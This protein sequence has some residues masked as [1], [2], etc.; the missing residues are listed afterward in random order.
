[1]G[2]VPGNRFMARLRKAGCQSGFWLSSA[3][4][5]VAEVAGGAGFDFAVIDAEHSPNTITTILDQ[6]RVLEAA[7][8]DPIVRP[9]AN[10]AIR[11]R[12]CLDIG[13]RTILVPMVNTAREAEEAVRATRYPPAGI[14]GVSMGH[15]AF[16]YGRRANYLR[17]ADA[18]ICVIPQIET[19]EAVANLEA[20]A[21]VDGVAAVFV[22]PAD[23]TADMGLI[24]QTDHAD[25]RALLADIA[26]RCSALGV[27]FGTLAAGADQARA[28]RALGAGFVAA[29]TDIGLLRQ[30][31]DALVG[32]LGTHG[33][34]R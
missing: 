28:R 9:G 27:R 10:D 18:E 12:Q 13:A 30:A 11:I 2:S 31:T 25:Y 22:G 21:S 32:Y 7:S 6:I 1:M 19:L 33:D 34:E 29:G 20:I 8:V 14:R 15:R 3:S 24:G 23:L 16:G 17:E 4:A 26:H 5:T